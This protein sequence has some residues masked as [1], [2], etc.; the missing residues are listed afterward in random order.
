M[1]GYKIKQSDVKLISSVNFIKEEYTE[2]S[3]NIYINA[4][5][6]Y[7]VNEYFLVAKIYKDYKAQGNYTYINGIEKEYKTVKPVLNAIMKQ[8]SNCSLGMDKVLEFTK[9]EKE[10]P[11][12][13]EIVENEIIETTPVITESNETMDICK[14]CKLKGMSV[15][16]YKN[17]KSNIHETAKAIRST[18]SYRGGMYY[19]TST[20]FNWNTNT[21]IKGFIINDL[22][23]LGIEFIQDYTE[24]R[25][26]E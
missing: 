10:I 25:V 7:G 26:T 19:P 18:L 11:E 12:V 15:Q 17:F 20:M 5:M 2:T 8:Y 3:C 14:Y 4:S 16:E 22:K 23:T 6:S 9:V 13:T 21:D 24:Y 1:L